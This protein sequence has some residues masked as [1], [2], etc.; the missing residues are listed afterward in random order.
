MAI[1]RNKL[2]AL[3]GDTL[4]G[5]ARTGGLELMYVHLQSLRNLEKV[6]ARV[7]GDESPDDE[8]PEVDS[9]PESTRH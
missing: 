3:P 1:E 8:W 6:L 9:A 4:A 7:S 5:L 2:K